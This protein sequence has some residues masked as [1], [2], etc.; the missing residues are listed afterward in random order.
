M[1]KL[2]FKGADG[3]S[4]DMRKL[5]FDKDGKVSEREW[6]AYHQTAGAAGMG[7]GATQSGK[8]E[9]KGS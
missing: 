3:K 9:K 1:K 2:A 7:A 6:A 4:V 5:D 8:S